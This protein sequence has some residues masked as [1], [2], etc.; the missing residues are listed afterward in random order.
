MQLDVDDEEVSTEVSKDGENSDVFVP[1]SEWQHVKEGQSIPRGL[2][3]RLNMATGEREA[4]LNEKNSIQDK[5]SERI[6][7]GNKRHHTHAELKKA[8]KEFKADMDDVKNPMEN[9]GKTNDFRSYEEI[10]EEFA[11][12]NWMMKT[13]AEIITGLVQ[14]YRNITTSES[15]KLAIFEDLEYYLHQVDNAQLFVDLNA[16]NIAKEALNS[17][18][19]QLKSISALLLGSAAQS[20]PKVQIAMIEAG[21]LQDLVRYFSNEPDESIQ[22]RLLFACL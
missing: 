9:T 8:L 21:I 5:N 1:T 19:S 12:L 6:A 2:H 7:D 15:R 18:N 3:V 14:E 17:S 16:L 11:K 10:K 13:E 4:K 20:N 22:K